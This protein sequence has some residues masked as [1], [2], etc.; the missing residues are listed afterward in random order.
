MVDAAKLYELSLTVGTS[1]RLDANCDRFLAAL[2]RLKE[3]DHAAVWLQHR[4]LAGED[5]SYGEGSQSTLVRAASRPAADR[6]AL[7]IPLDHPLITMLE[8]QDSVALSVPDAR[9]RGVLG[10]D[11]ERSGHAAVYRLGGLGFLLL[12]SG[13][14]RRPFMRVEIK[15]LDEV[16]ATFARS[17]EGCLAHHQLAREGAARR[18]L[19]SELAHREA[20][21]R[22]LIENAIDV[23]LLVGYDNTLTF[24]SPS[25]RRALAVEPEQLVGRSLLE[26]VHPEQ[27]MQVFQIFRTVADRPGPGPSFELRLKHGDLSWRSFA[28][29]TNNLLA[30][31]A[32][33]AVILNLHDVTE[34]NEIREALRH[35]EQRFA[36][37]VQG[38]TD[39]IWDW[40]LLTDQV[41]FSRRW[42]EIVGLAELGTR[43][44]EW[45]ER[46]HPEDLPGLHAALDA[47][48]RG[49]TEQLQHEYRI[50]HGDGSWRW[51]LTRGVAIHDTAGRPARIAGSQSD[52]TVRVQQTEE[53]DRA[54][55]Q[56]LAAS[57]ARGEFL[58]NMSHELRTPMNGVIGM[59]SL[60]LDSPLTPEQHEFVSIVRSSG[61]ALLA[62]VND[63]LDLSKIESGKLQILDEPFSVVDC[64][65][66]AVDIVA[67]NVVH[68]GIDLVYSVDP[69]VPEV[70]RGD[71]V[72]TR[73]V[74]VNVLSN[75]VKFTEEGEV[76]VTVAANDDDGRCQLEFQVRDTGLG[77]SGEQV[78]RLFEPFTQADAS[79]TRRF[80]GTGL[81]LAICRRLCQQM[82][83]RI[84]VRSEP[85]HG[86]TFTFTIS[87]R[88]VEGAELEAPLPSLMG[89]RIIFVHASDTAGA[90][91][92]RA[93]R[94]WQVEASLVGD[95][96]GAARLARRSKVPVAVV[97]DL[98]ST[99]LEV[100]ACLERLAGDATVPPVGVVL[101][102]PLGSPRTEIGDPP[103]GV[104]VAW[105]N[106]PIKP[107]RLRQT[108]EK[109]LHESDGEQH[110]PERPLPVPYLAEPRERPLRILLA[111]DN[112]VNRRMMTIMLERL[113]CHAEVARTGVE[114]VEACA[115]E[116]FD[117]ILMDV[118]MPE[119]DG[120]E[121]TR[122]IRELA[123]EPLPSIIAVTAHAMAGDRERCLA[124]GMDDYLPKPIQLHELRAVLRRAGERS[125]AS[126][127]I[128]GPAAEPIDSGRI[129][130]LREIGSSDL[131]LQMI[132]IFLEEAPAQ[133]SLLEQS[134]EDGD[135]QALA[136]TAHALKGSA[137]A[138]GA[139][140]LANL[141]QELETL[142]ETG[143]LADVPP[144]LARL[145]AELSRT[146]EVLSSLAND[147]RADWTPDG[148]SKPVS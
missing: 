52:V 70:F 108:L 48:L 134:V 5:A 146:G 102:K 89:S 25:V 6:G 65:E 21:F 139:V 115:R 64:V 144:M 110:E 29:S 62:I 40:D 41:Y 54:R 90:A 114:A 27:V 55:Q 147:A 124:N 16:V 119:M 87:G 26:R 50:R 128:A 14:R 142:A 43:P 137:L 59:A 8:R 140:P 109:V 136:G 36:L 69:S 2:V 129:D 120:F 35:S 101:V 88:R 15:E 94:P 63:V 49:K 9:L 143:R 107:R 76:E 7:P 79:T 51:A 31:T 123:V 138:L 126:S 132:A 10:A 97:V 127:A 92:V 20:H 111:E 39:G 125:G 121:A 17:L 1:I 85:G 13:S 22:A 148:M 46:V 130:K 23:I 28:A 103:Q 131:V 133:L 104:R 145:G 77:I 68:K 81:G 93:T 98:A 91:L 84:S 105:V 100:G 141:C 113:G 45:F 57:R 30:D 96:P 19:Q 83:G 135:T 12:H 11:L 53:L 82:G 18:R 34:R 75:A 118:Q 44:S 37:A 71:V 95:V 86:A 122:R 24:A 66:H 99:D 3:L 72:R 112:Q 60:L 106:S 67:P 56:A 32:V 78:E 4:L 74:L 80:G 42:A 58:A 33:N 47:H 38:S 116:A 117:V 61:Q 73:Q